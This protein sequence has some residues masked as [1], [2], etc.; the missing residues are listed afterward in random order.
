[1]GNSSSEEICVGSSVIFNVDNSSAGIGRNYPGS[2]YVVNF[3]DGSK[4]TELTQSQLMLNPRIEH[5][6]E[7]SSCSETGS[8][9]Y[10]EKNLYSKGIAGSCNEYQ[11]NGSGVVKRVNA[12]QPPSASFI[13]V[14]SC[15]IN[16]ALKLRNTSIPGFYGTSGCKDASNFYWY[17]K[18]PGDTN[19]TYVTNSEWIDSSS[20]LRI[21]G[22][23]INK[24]GCWEFKL[25]AQN[26]D[27]CQ[28]LSTFKATV[29]VEEPAAATFTC[30]TDSVCKNESITF[31]NTSPILANSCSKPYFKWIVTPE[32]PENTSGFA[33]INQTTT[34]TQNAA[35][36]FSEPGYYQVQLE[37]TNSC[38][39]YLS[40]SKRVLIYG[41]PAI[42]L[43]TEEF[44]ICIDNQ[45]NDTVDFG[46][47][48][49]NPDF[50]TS[51]HKIESYE[52][53]ISGESV[54][55]QDYEYILGTKNSAYP[56]IKF[57]T[58]KAYEI[59][60]VVT[61]KCGFTATK[62]F[63][64]SFNQ[65][66]TLTNTDTQQH[67]CS[68]EKF[69]DI[70]PESNMNNI[71]YEWQVEKSSFIN[72]N[73]EN[74]SGNKIEG[75]NLTN[76]S[77]SVG[78][79]KYTITPKTSTC[80]GKPVD[81]TIYVCPEI[82]VEQPN[83][84]VLKHGEQSGVINFKS[85]IKN[86]T[87]KYNWTCDRPEIGLAAN[88]NGNLPLFI[89][90]NN[91]NEAITATITVLPEIA[92]DD[93]NCEGNSQSFKIT[94]LPEV[95]V[96]QIQDY[97]LCNKQ[98]FDSLIFSTKNI[99]GNTSYEWTNTNSEI[100]LASSGTGY[101][102]SFIAK[103]NTDTITHATISVTAI[104]NNSGNISKSTPRL[105]TISV[106]PSPFALI[107]GDA[108]ICSGAENPLITISGFNGK[109]PY[110]FLY[111]INNSDI[112]TATT[113]NNDTSVQFSI[114]TTEAA[115]FVYKLIAVSDA[116]NECTNYQNDSAVVVIAPNPMITKQ[117]VK[118]QNICIGGTIEPL[119]IEFDGGTGG[120]IIRWYSNQIDSNENGT[121]IQSSNKHEFTPSF[122]KPGSYYYYAMVIK[123]GS[124][125]GTAISETAT[126]NVYSDPQITTQAIDS[127]AICINGNTK[128]LQIETNTSE[129]NYLWYKS[130]TTNFADAIKIENA[131]QA[132][133]TPA[134]D[135]AGVFYYFCEVTRNFSGCS[136]ISEPSKLQ[137]Y[138]LPIVT[139]QPESFQL[140]KND[141]LPEISINYINGTPNVQYQWY[142][143]RTNSFLDA[144]QIS[145]ANSKN[146]KIQKKDVGTY[147]YFCTINF[148][149]ETCG[150]LVSEPS[151]IIINQYPVIGSQ[152]IETASQIPFI[153]TPLNNDIIP[154]STTYTWTIVEVI[155]SGS[156]SGANE[157]QNS[158]HQIYQ[159]LKNN[160]NNT[161][162]IK[163]LITPQANNCI[164][165]SF[166]LLVKVQ[167][168]L[169]VTAKQT[170]ITCNGN[171]DGN[172]LVNIS[173]GIPYHLLPQYKILWNG[174][175]GFTSNK[176]HI[177]NLQKGN[178][179]LSVADS[180]GLTLDTTF[181]IIE[182]EQIKIS[183]NSIN[184]V[185]C[186][187]A[188]NGNIN[189][190]I[191]GGT[192]NYK[193]HWTKNSLFFSE[194]QHIE[195][196]E[197]ALYQLTVTD[198]F[199]CQQAS[200]LFEITEPDSINIKLAKQIN[201]I[202]YGDKNGSIDVTIEGG[203]SDYTYQWKSSNGFVSHEK[204]ISGLAAGIYELTVIDALGCEAHFS[205]EI[206]QNDDI[207]IN[208]IVKPVSCY[209]SNDASI[210][211]EISG[212]IS[213][214]YAVWNNL[215]TGLTQDN[216]APGTYEILVTDK[217][218]CSKNVKIIIPNDSLFYIKPIINNVSCYGAKN[219]RI[220]LN[221]N[222]GAK[223][224]T[225]KWSDG[226]TAGS[227][228]NNMAPGIYSVEI[229]NGSLCTINESFTI[230]EPAKITISGNVTHAMSCDSQ[231]G[232]TIDANIRGGQPPYKLIWSNGATT[233]TITDLEAGDYYLTVIDSAGCSATETFTIIR[234]L[235]IKLEVESQLSFDCESASV[236][237]T[238]VASVSGGIP[239]YRLT[240]SGGNVSGING[241]RMISNKNMT[242]FVTA[243]DA[244]GCVKE[245]AINNQIPET[246]LRINILNCD[247][248]LYQ[249]DMLVPES[250][251]DN[252]KYHWEFGDG[253][254]SDS[255][256]PV[257]IYMQT[258]NYNIN[259]KLSTASCE[260]NLTQILVVD[261]MPELKLD[262]RPFLCPNDSVAIR[263]SGAKDYIWSDGSTGDRIVIKE[264]GLYSVTGKNSNGCTSTL[265]FNAQYFSNL[266]YDIFSNKDFA[267]SADPTIN[268]WSNEI[269]SSVYHWDFGEYGF[270][271]PETGS[272]VTHTFNITQIQPQTI[273]LSI[274]NPFGC[275][276]EVTKKIWL[277][278]SEIPNLFTPNGDGVNEVFLPNTDLEIYNSSGHLLYKGTTGWDGTYNGQE[279]RTDTYYYV[280]YFYSAEGV[281][282]K[283][284]YIAL[285]R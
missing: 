200:H 135:I 179:H 232:G 282:K 61:G 178:Y 97:V 205:T 73:I 26:K 214:Y 101:I 50:S 144:E 30:S 72:A 60:I 237:Q 246:G 243:T 197:P 133:Y 269:E 54:T 11:K 89:A 65:I 96:N 244:M 176:T 192:G 212:G 231:S 78:Y 201:N 55:D 186:K 136:V 230:S 161:A 47:S 21:P 17:Y 109:K 248:L 184:H 191:T 219:G 67:I 188:A 42:N 158:Q 8:F 160:T 145:G 87:V 31:T 85:N 103:N 7:N 233:K 126:I 264:A 213:P 209:G 38:G 215:A 44:K 107:T 91:T 14:S 62:K 265:S 164:G 13:V 20:T 249:F 29:M 256:N 119:N 270:E 122:D 83:D 23:I 227:T 51:E 95:E 208:S 36:Q 130:N 86:Q 143:S 261:N 190:D 285:I 64:I 153:F 181:I 157:Q 110:T 58:L 66:P 207:I 94:I 183:L 266:Q 166:E 137:V 88:G 194:F 257:H 187:G 259:L 218:G 74:G 28:T 3:G 211:L 118:E 4:P 57:N 263:V 255:K 19:F 138:S 193:Y 142:E 163:Y 63:N 238:N 216:L 241:N 32:K 245:L 81:F 24:S 239:P 92:S 43:S 79:V 80:D 175:N 159:Q 172:I 70:V 150:Q 120:T 5:K 132:E 131:Q 2:K 148:N 224:V 102:P 154:Q 276:Q 279:L 123:D 185:S 25:E 234:P 280:A 82:I 147:F 156:I 189:V 35:I 71:S 59:Q 113:S 258:G 105:F 76:T 217:A 12:S 100:G 1:M 177:N 152:S 6:F 27:L 273:K 260:F 275:T 195:N 146:F 77:D 117:P 173:G 121:L 271:Q 168:D 140:C 198:E 93:F 222:A 281:V 53:M 112:L 90:T 69:M 56:A 223:N 226:S 162:T 204:N 247:N 182:P 196:L 165:K 128:K 114:S 104:Y 129:C 235:P 45:S 274:I 10:I 84:I 98:T 242:V 151:Q 37:I 52:W 253:S 228:R 229:S 220:Q 155:P 202:C 116:A 250:L 141:V 203:T 106:K 149:T 34:T 46:S 108:N 240:W 75:I 68:G 124:S 9:F 278:T 127:Q 174:P 225:L 267:T 171:T 16:S 221:I 99:D 252:L 33:F 268:F 277:M 180:A 206:T 48:S 170:N 272:S 125:C 22:S 139:E 111:Q 134:S 115:K 167:P 199:N 40:L 236:L 284:G 15:C 41:E 49:Y 169:K 254:S 18:K 39:K 262:K 283:T 251:E 210:K